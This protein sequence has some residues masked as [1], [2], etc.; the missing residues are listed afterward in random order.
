MTDGLRVKIMLLEECPEE[1]WQEREI[2]WISN[3]D[4]LTN[5]TI[6]GEGKTGYIATAESRAKMSLSHMGHS[7]SKESR[8]R[9]SMAIMGH[10]VSKETRAKMSLANTGKRRSDETKAKISLASTGRYHSE[11][12]I[13]KMRKRRPT[14]ETRKKLREGRRKY[15]SRIKESNG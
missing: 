13:A 6:G 1:K 14:E 10:P 8:L 2:F 12:S 7:P 11:E 15:L 5:Q 3:F 4:G 9:Q